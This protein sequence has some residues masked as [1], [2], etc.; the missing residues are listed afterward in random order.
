MFSTGKI[1]LWSIIEA[2]IGIIAGSLPALRP[3]L[4]HPL[5]SRSADTSKGSAGLTSSKPTHPSS[6]QHE[7]RSNVEM[8]TFHQ[9]GGQDGDIDRERDGDSQKHILK[10]T[11]VT[12][13]RNQR[14]DDWTDWQKRQVLGWR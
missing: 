4:S 10:E 2:G 13:V 12:V 3:L 6:R 8:D 5:L 14:T 9:L 11:H 7:F 1:G